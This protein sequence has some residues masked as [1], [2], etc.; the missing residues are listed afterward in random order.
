MNTNTIDKPSDDDK[1]SR[2]AYGLANNLPR[3]LR[4]F[5]ND[6][7]WRIWQQLAG[8]GYPDVRRSYIAVFANIGTGAVRVSD[9]AE[10]ARVTQQAMGK[11]LKEIE[12]LGYIRRDIDSS[13]R[14]AKAIRLTDRGLDLVATALQVT[15]EVRAEYAK[16]IGQE[17]LDTLEDD[18]RRAV[19]RLQLEFMPDTWAVQ[20]TSD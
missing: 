13:D 3:L 20:R 15:A 4:E 1:N 7:E 10:R 12:G 11:M 18:L 17:E 16:K 14:R 19:H 2:I 8:R 9:L 6:Y 5:C